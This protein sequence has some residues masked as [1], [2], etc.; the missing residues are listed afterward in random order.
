MKGTRRHDYHDRIIDEAADWF[1]RL[2][3]CD[4]STK[5]REAF[6]DWL[7][8]SSEH[9]REYLALANLH[10]EIAEAPGTVSSNDLIDLARAANSQNVIPLHEAAAAS[11]SSFALAEQSSNARAAGRRG[12]VGAIALLALVCV[13]WLHPDDNAARYTTGIG[14]QNSFPLA[15]GSLITLNAVSSVHVHF[16]NHF[17]DVQLVSGEALFT[18]AKNPDRPFRVLINDGVI[19]AVGTQFNVYHR[20][21]DTTVTVV[22]GT[23][24]VSGG[25]SSADAANW[26]PVKAGQRAQ[27]GAKAAPIIVNDVDP[28]VDTSWRERRLVFQSRPL[29]EVVAEFNLYNETA[30]VISDPRLNEVRVSGSFYTNDPRSFALFLQEAK[31]A[32]QKDESTRIVLLAPVA[33]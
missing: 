8:G 24:R 16:T 5:D 9:V 31:L 3:D 22:E 20:G 19:Q 28:S 29:S 30:L 18:V 26:V 13:L 15:D 32:K 33:Q 14:E 7:S 11:G 10:A 12:R 21:E 1:I 25:L 6:S 17:R 4:L 2:Q 27:V 23:V